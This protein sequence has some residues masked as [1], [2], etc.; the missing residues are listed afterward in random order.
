MSQRPTQCQCNAVLQRTESLNL[1]FHRKT[2][3]EQEA[4]TT[5][6]G[7]AR[8]QLVGIEL[9]R[10]EDYLRQ[11]TRGQQCA[12]PVAIAHEHALSTAARNGGRLHRAEATS[13]EGGASRRLKRVEG[14]ESG[15]RRYKQ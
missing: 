3:V 8:L 6:V 11:R 7:S 9:L 10:C 14:R 4:Q 13:Y 12:R 15:G 2:T 1:L 5:T